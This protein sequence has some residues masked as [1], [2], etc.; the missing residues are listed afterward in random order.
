VARADIFVFC[1]YVKA[2]TRKGRRLEDGVTTVHQQHIGVFPSKMCE[3]TLVVEEA[4]GA[5]MEARLGN[6]PVEG[7]AGVGAKPATGSGGETQPDERMKAMPGF[8][9]TDRRVAIELGGNDDDLVRAEVTVGLLGEVSGDEDEI[10]VGNI[11]SP[12]LYERCEL[13]RRV[14]ARDRQNESTGRIRWGRGF[15]GVWGIHGSLR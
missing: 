13:C 6:L 8:P 1:K 15:S 12:A 2:L 3:V 7:V 9:P 10:G 14:A 4:L 5:E 11:A